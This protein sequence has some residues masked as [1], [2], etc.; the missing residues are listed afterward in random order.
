MAPSGGVESQQ[1]LL[2]LRLVKR[3][4]YAML[5]KAPDPARSLARSERLRRPDRAT[6]TLSRHR[7]DYEDDIKQIRTI[8]G[9]AAPDA[10]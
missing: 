9:I 4:V 8:I 6:L 2:L 10:R 7:Q 3:G 1:W 5:A